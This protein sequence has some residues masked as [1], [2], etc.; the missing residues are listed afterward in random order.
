MLYWLMENECKHAS[1]IV[2]FYSE[3]PAKQQ[4]AILASTASELHSS[5]LSPTCRTI[6]T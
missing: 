6:S 2:E 1:H 5:L 3:I 4:G